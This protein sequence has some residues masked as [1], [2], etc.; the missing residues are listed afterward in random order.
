MAVASDGSLYIA[1]R[2]N[3]R[4]RKVSPDGTI[5]TVAGNGSAGFSGD[6]GSAVDAQLFGPISVAVEPGGTLLVADSNNAAVRRVWPSGIITA[7]AG[8]PRFRD[9]T[10]PANEAAFYFPNAVGLDPD[11]D[12][13]IVD[14]FNHVIRR[15]QSDQTLETMVG[16]GVRGASVGE[17]L[18][19]RI[20]MGRPRDVV[21]DSHGKLYVSEWLNHW[22]RIV[23]PSGIT[24][25]FLGSG[26]RGSNVESSPLD[27]QLTL[28]R[29]LAIDVDDNLYV[30]DSSNHQILRVR[31][32][33][34]DVVAGTGERGFSGD[35]GLARLARLNSP[36]GM[37]FDSDGN[38]YVAD[39]FNHRIRK[40]SPEG[41]IETFAGDGSRGFF[42][43][44]GQAT[45]ARLNEPHR[46]KFD[47]DGYLYIGDSYNHVIRMITPAGF[48][49]TIAGS[50]LDAG[51]DGDGGLALDAKLNLPKGLAIKPNGDV[52][53]SDNDNHRIRIL[54]PT[55][56]L[57]DN[58]AVN[59]AGF[60]PILAPGSIA[61]LF[62]TN[63]GGESAAATESPLP[64]RL[65]FSRI[66]IVDS[67]GTEHEAGQFFAS[68]TQNNFLV[69]AGVSVGEATITL[70]RDNGSEASTAVAIAAVAPGLF[71][72]A[73]FLR[74]LAD[75][76][77][78]TGLTT[79]SLDLGVAGDQ[80]FLTVFAT[81][82][83]NRSGLSAVSVTVGG[84]PV[85]V[86]FAGAHSEFFGLDQVDIGPL[87]RS[88]EGRGPVA[89]T[90]MVDGMIANSIELN[91][92]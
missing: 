47:A 6:G 88:L 46:I 82:L 83:R 13:L 10:G 11:G 89:V 17:G 15:V 16:N 29:G 38:L 69:P 58:A 49:H 14:S 35:G 22:V 50:P 59:A 1:D 34:V 26:E 70:T 18:T 77:R 85:P 31:R 74:V 62:G 27:T 2:D 21:F 9:E 91:I 48:I 20:P 52:I 32:G 60:K 75:N 55:P 66:V 90:A 39:T 92:Q 23:E 81:G 5:D 19:P 43:D 65:A 57:L 87:P 12:P 61:S 4:I 24:R 71:R 68:K 53:F 63:L 42:G 86:R 45:A 3:H 8:G 78:E 80:V 44:G 40:I 37:D 30:S 33:L 67:A 79:V 41:R 56:R 7:V 54:Q 73:L 25:V 28:P 84:E 72:P 51:D 36:R 76:S 64:T